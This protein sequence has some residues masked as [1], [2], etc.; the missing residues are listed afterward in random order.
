MAAGR[1][2]QTGAG[3][4]ETGNGKRKGSGLRSFTVF[5]FPFFDL[6][7]EGDAVAACQSGTG[8]RSPRRRR[9]PRSRRPSRRTAEAKP[10]P[11]P[12][13]PR[14]VPPAACRA[15]RP[16]E[17]LA[18][19]EEERAHAEDLRDDRDAREQ[20]RDRHGEGGWK[21]RE[22]RHGRQQQRQNA[23]RS[24][25]QR[26]RPVAVGGGGGARERRGEA[27]EEGEAHG[28]PDGEGDQAQP[29]TRERAPSCQGGW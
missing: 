12:R 4:R 26:P 17:L 23:E 13:A 11:G 24:G 27:E 16:Q 8:R 3:K 2:N 19:Q 21:K 29:A 20:D 25:E 18:E 6:G 1:L 9:T 15:R 10:L 5:R 22:R 7:G 14:P 28:E